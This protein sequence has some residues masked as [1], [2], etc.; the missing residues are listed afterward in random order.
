MSKQRVVLVPKQSKLQ[1]QAGKSGVSSELLE[2]Q[3]KKEGGAVLKIIDSHYR[4]L[5]SF[6]KVTKSLDN[7][8]IITRDNFPEKMPEDTKVVITLGGD[9]HFL[10][11]ARFLK[12]QILVGINSDSE[13]SHG[14]LLQ[15]LPE[16][17][18]L[19]KKY[20]ESLDFPIAKCTRLKVE[21]DGRE[22][23]QLAN[24]VI[25]IGDLITLGMSRYILKF[26]DWEE[27][28]KSSGLIISTGAGLSGWYQ[29]ATRFWNEELMSKFPKFE[30]QEKKAR[31]V[32]REIYLGEKGIFD[33]REGEVLEVYSLMDNDAI[34]ST[35]PDRYDDRFNYPFLRGSVVKI[36]ISEKPLRV[37]TKQ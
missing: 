27:E 17:I 20:I 2:K 11:I 29:G 25:Y 4:Q 22:L 10:H 16:D 12:E 30:K 34:V 1:Y 37:A 19:I 6:E 14:D 15:F 33:L 13:T 35:D 7:P 23:P 8:L 26:K 9:G 31:V 18:G 24:S 36:S 3:Y 5:E 32:A 21:L 28:Q